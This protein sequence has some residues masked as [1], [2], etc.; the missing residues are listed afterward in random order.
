MLT[1]GMKPSRRST[2]GY[3]RHSAARRTTAG[4]AQHG[5]AQDACW[6]TGWWTLSASTPGVGRSTAQ[7]G[8]AQRRV[9][10]PVQCRQQGQ[11]AARL[12][13]CPEGAGSSGTTGVCCTGP[14]PAQGACR[15]PCTSALSM[16]L[17]VLI[18]RALQA[19]LAAQWVLPA[20]V[21][22]VPARCSEGCTGLDA[23]PA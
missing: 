15:C 18:Y 11:A 19:A 3:S 17:A 7:H 8:T 5:A 9:C 21:A 1:P 20:A 4:T 10:L 23:C 12:P 13:G 22:A 6:W 2:A 16:C 14:S